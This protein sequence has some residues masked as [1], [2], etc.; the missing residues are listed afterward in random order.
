MQNLTLK[1]VVN[2]APNKKYPQFGYWIDFVDASGKEYF[3]ESPISNGRY[4]FLENHVYNFDACTKLIKF[5][6]LPST[7]I[8]LTRIKNIREVNQ[9]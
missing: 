7:Y 2:F 8:K 1:V 6:F 5:Q 3:V 4:H 9:L